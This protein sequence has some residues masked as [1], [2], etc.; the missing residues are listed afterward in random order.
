MKRTLFQRVMCM[1]LTLTML[2]GAFALTASAGKLKGNESTSSTLEEMQALVST[3]SYAEYLAAY[4]DLVN[5]NL[6]VITLE[7]SDLVNNV[8]GDAFVTSLNDACNKSYTVSPEKWA[9]F[10]W[11]KNADSTVY[12]P[13]L[14]ADNKAGVATFNITV[15]EGQEGLYYIEIQYFSVYTS[16]SSV[17][18]IERKFKIN[19][20]VPFDEIS[21]IN[22]DKSWAYDNVTIGNVTDA[23]ADAALGTTT[24]YKTDDTGYYKYS[25]RVFEEG[26]VKKQQVTTYKI[27]Q[28]INGNSMSPEAVQS[29]DWSTY[30][31]HD[32][33][34]FYD[35]YFSFYI[36]YGEPS[37]TLEAER[38][39]VII[40]SISL[41]PADAKDLE[42]SAKSYDEYIADIKA[43]YSN[44]V[45][46]DGK[47][48]T[49]EAEFPT[50]VSDSSVAPSNN[51][52]SASNY[53]ISP[54]AQLFNVIGETG[55]NTVGQWA[56][57]KFTVNKTGLYKLSMR[58]MQS[59]LQGMFICRTVKLAGGN[60]YKYGLEDGSPTVPFDEAYRTR[61]N[62]DKKWQ[63]EYLGYYD[64]DNNQHTF[65]FYFEEGVEYTLS[66]ECSL[67]DLKTY[68][69]RVEAAL[70]VINECY[71]KIIQ[72]TGSDP[73]EYQSYDFIGSMPEV[74]VNLLLMAME[75][76]DISNGLEEL[77]GTTGSHIAT[78]DTVAR[79]LDTMGS[80]D[81]DNIAAN[82][83]TL[84]T[85][86]GTLGTWINDSKRG[87]LMIDSICVVPVDTD[88]DIPKAKA[89]FFKTIWFEISSFIYSFF[90][91]Y[92]QM[93]LTYDPS[94][95][96]ST[97]IDVW[98][99]SG[100]DQSNIW[101]T[102]IDASGSLGFTS[103]TGVGV[104]L[105]LVTGGTLLPSI[106]AGRGPD[107]YLG[108]GSA[109]V[110][111]Y[112]IRDAVM[113][114]SGDASDPND[115]FANFVYEYEDGTKVFSPK[116]LTAE[117]V[118]DKLVSTGHTSMRLV[119]ES[120]ASLTAYDSETKEG[121]FHPA[122]VNTLTLLEKSYGVP[123]TM[124]FAMMFYRMDILANLGLEVPESWDELLTALPILQTNNM[125]MGVSYI[126]AL[127]FMMYQMGGNMWKYTDNP[128]YAGAKID[129]DSDI[130]I[131]AFE[132]V[133]AL[134][135]DHSFP[136]SYDAANRF[137]T[138]EMPIVIGDYASI[139]NTLTVYATEI[140]GMWEFSSLPGSYEKSTGKFNYDS[141]AGVTATVI[142]NG[143]DEKLAAWQFV[144]WQTSAD[145]QANYA[146]R[147]VA[148]IGPS[149]KYESANLDAIKDMSWTANEKAAIMNQMD[150][151]DSIVNYPGSYIISRYMKFAFLD[152]YNDGAKARDAMM[153]YIDAMNDE[154]K[155]KR[156]EFGLSTLDK[157]QDPLT[158][159]S[160]TEGE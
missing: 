149:A 135:T 22:L 150:H 56:N 34:G 114:I 13:A 110:I 26:G 123:M 15:P 145:V 121:L 12:L 153:S 49:I 102:T 84:K 27:S 69:Q 128:E 52:T 33:S 21:T 11:E 17:S 125:E 80:K 109:D 71:L 116:E 160:N 20:Q 90:T 30:I 59:S 96:S 73:D 47:I 138:G 88:E 2:L 136:V 65:E 146:N 83:A 158:T 63:S 76:E 100:R 32:D 122:A 98:L 105:K 68:I 143:C 104:T 78:L 42:T 133:C 91:E 44:A 137:R 85:Y 31:C 53:P 16:E 159:E 5:S 18:S 99:A 74:P 36:P 113:C 14:G 115:P 66:L 64:D 60:E 40:K 67:G 72:L 82:M 154:I 142:L 148:L 129:L 51:N 29:P 3:S 7:G 156:E 126:S 45:A 95:V 24:E 132:F 81:G 57:Y 139:Y 25:T 118:N 8:S 108:L 127:D 41:I 151:L 35:G 55:Y 119:S 4:E 43:K 101:R 46:A 93:G 141:L 70:D 58:Y 38:E 147:M 131:E 140:D 10:D 37:I 97:T 117:E 54:A 157:G 130:A 28:D 112:A 152:V 92:D 155:R 77:C 19:G 23:P 134:Y 94:E 124:G 75:L 107:V 103:N 1:L 6:S 79:L 111:N 86:L 120:F 62:Y 39:P 89:G 9:N 87:T 61:F 48:V 106:L 50:N 144:Q